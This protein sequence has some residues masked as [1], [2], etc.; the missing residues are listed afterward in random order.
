MF[1]WDKKKS[2]ETLMQ[3]RKAGGGELSAG[4]TPMKEEHVSEIG[5]DPDI[6]HLAAEDVMDAFHSK[7]ADRLKDSLK[8]FI[9]LHLSAKDNDEPDAME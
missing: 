7:S 5:G 9:D 4:P 8:N 1:M 6:H 2:L 3:K